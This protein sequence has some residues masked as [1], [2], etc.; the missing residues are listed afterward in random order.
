MLGATENLAVFALSVALGVGVLLLLRRARH[1]RPEAGPDDAVGWHIGLVGTAYAVI[2]AFMLSGVW[3]NFRTA[4]AN[5]SAEA[6]DLVNLFRLAEGLPAPQRRQLQ[7]LCRTY[8]S[9]AI[10][11]EWPAMQGDSLSPPG[12]SVTQ[13]LWATLMRADVHSPLEQTSL[14]AA[15]GTLGSM[16][17]HRRIRQ[18]QSHSRLPTILWVVLIAGG[19]STVG[20]ACTYEVRSARLH[21]FQVVTLS[22]LIGLVLLAVA[23]IDRPFQGAVHVPPDGFAFAR[24]TFDQLAPAP[25]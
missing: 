9:V 14:A 2:S 10:E 25:R 17:E 19:L 8:A 21:T 11:Q 3:T 13:Q 1:P 16:T 4:E 20:A 22:S 15:L 18:L 5:A 24:A 6:T 7:A 23:D 12:F